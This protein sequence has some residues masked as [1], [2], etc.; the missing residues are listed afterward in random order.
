VDGILDVPGPIAESGLE[1]VFTWILRIV[2]LLAVLAGVGLWAS[3]DVGLLVVPG[4]VMAIGVVL[5]AA[6][7][8]PLLA[9]ELA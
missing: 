4:A 7:S 9:A 3:T 1:G 2:G 6:P 5:L 8:V